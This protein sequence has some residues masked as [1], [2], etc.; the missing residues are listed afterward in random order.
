[1]V[2]KAVVAN[3]AVAALKLAGPA[4]AVGPIGGFLG[5]SPELAAG[6][7]L[8]P[9]VLHHH[10][11]AVGGIPAGVG[12]GDGGGD[13]PPVGL[14]HQQHGPGAWCLRAPDATGQAGAIATGHLLV[15][16]AHPVAARGRGLHSAHIG[17]VEPDHI[18]G[19]Y[20]GVHG[21]EVFLS[22]NLGDGLLGG[23]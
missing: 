11:E 22:G 23:G 20:L 9:H 13:C 10:Q 17:A 5:K 21:A 1:M 18:G 3:L 4:D 15:L 16:P 19:E 6:V 14:A 12:V 2:G 8:A 7:P